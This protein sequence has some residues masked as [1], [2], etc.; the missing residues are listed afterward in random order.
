MWFSSVPGR[1]PSRRLRPR[2]GQGRQGATRRPSAKWRPSLEF[3]ED[4]CLLSA[5]VGGLSFLDP[6][7]YG[8]GRS[9]RSVAVADFNGDQVPDAA[10]ANSASNDVSVFLG[11]GDG[12]LL[13]G[14]TIAA[15]S[16]P[17]FLTTGDFNGDRLTDL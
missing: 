7:D 1:A 9:P 4:R 11:G 6:V 13:P 14:A 8:V 17:S 10:V 15:G 16:R 5:G 12:S 3:L 2:L